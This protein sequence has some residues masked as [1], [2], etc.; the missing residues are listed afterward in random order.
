[1]I[2]RRIGWLLGW[3]ALAALVAP[4]VYACWLSFTPDE[5][6]TPPVGDWSIRW[7]REFFRSPR[8]TTALRESLLVGVLAVTY[9]LAA[10]LP[11]AYA[12]ARLHLRGE[13]VLLGASFCPWLPPLLLGIGL[14]PTVQA[15]GLWVTL[16]IPG[17]WRRCS[18]ECP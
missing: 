1:M 17:A 11:L 15:L 5:F 4:L 3:L 13:S 14:L 10:G 8:W 16:D 12:L 18:T 2:A 7:Y 6:L 9:S